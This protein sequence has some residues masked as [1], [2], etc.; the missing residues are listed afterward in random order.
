MGNTRTGNE[1]LMQFNP[2]IE[3]TLHKAKRAL[4]DRSLSPFKK[5]SEIVNTAAELKI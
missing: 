3:R 2:E 1:P 5:T 4:K